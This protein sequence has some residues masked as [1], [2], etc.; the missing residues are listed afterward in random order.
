MSVLYV[1]NIDCFITEMLFNKKVTFGLL[2]F[3]FS[4]YMTKRASLG[5]YTTIRETKTLTRCKLG[6]I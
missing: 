4:K 3:P 1:K 2:I 5:A 6:R